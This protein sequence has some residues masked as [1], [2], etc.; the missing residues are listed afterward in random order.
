MQ[1]FVLFVD[2]E[3]SILSA[4]KRVFRKTNHKVL[5]ASTTE[6]ALTLIRTKPISVLVSDYTMPGLT[7]AELLAQAKNIRPDMTRIILSGNGD[8]DATIQSINRGAASRFLTKPW[9]DQQLVNEIDKA[10]A[11]WEMGQFLNRDK[12]LLNQAAF[13][14]TVANLYSK[15]PANSF[16]LINFA[17]RD[18]AG[19]R[20]RI[21]RDR[22][23]DFLQSIIPSQ[24]PASDCAALGI[25][26]DDRFCALLPVESDDEQV[27]SVL[28]EFLG[29]F[30]G[31]VLFEDQ[32]YQVSIEAGFHVIE[33]TSLDVS[34]VI[35]HAEM[36]Y[37]QAKDATRKELVEYSPEMDEKKKN[38]RVLENGLQDAQSG[39]E[40]T[41]YY[42]PKINTLDGSMHGAEALIR[43]NSSSFGMVPPNQFIPLAERDD[44]ILDLGHWVMDEAARQWVSWFGNRDVSATISVNVSTKQLE[45]PTFIKRLEQVL[46]RTE[47]DASRFELEI[48]ESL[49]MMNVHETVK[50]LQDIKKLGVMLSIDDFGTGYSSLSHLSLLPIDTLKIDRSFIHPMQAS[51]ESRDLVRN[52]IKL[53][54]DLGVH[55]VAEGVEEEKQLNILRAYGCDVIQGYYFSP[56]V[57]AA[58]YTQL[59]ER[60][61]A[62]Q[63]S[64]SAQ[65]IYKF[66]S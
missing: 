6:D 47:I 66:A 45:D 58:D 60:Y 57:P 28:A 64:S 56:P 30:S 49:M 62:E 21:G 46:E 1:S 4:I 19:M 50:V 24:L 65:S 12:K 22:V 54:H 41:L 2:D 51:R 5:T 52:L 20:T 55:I 39:N 34:Q 32:K 31:T 9:D 35:D 43:W 40:F 3:P 14:E 33:D 42:Q 8:Q 38:L 53:G 17:V 15:E 23:L 44:T 37:Q 13:E 36:A 10:Y 59:I 18:L 48:T 26:A 61:P 11:E 29:Q 7:G 16:A 63:K 25:L 27:E